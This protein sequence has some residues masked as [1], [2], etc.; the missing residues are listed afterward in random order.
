[1]S[2][3]ST[4]PEVAWHAAFLAFL[5]KGELRIA[6]DRRTGAVI[7]FCDINRL[8]DGAA[9]IEWVPCGGKARLVSFTVYHRQY[10][11]DFV[12]PYNVA[13]VAFEEGPHLVATVI[14]EPERLS[15]G[16][17]LTASFEASGR[18]VFLPARAM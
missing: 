14:A 9:R 12:P 11:P 17:P 18:L 6:H 3:H 16:M 7:D 15:I 5:A 8:G 13:L 1:M 2:G 4:T 10:H